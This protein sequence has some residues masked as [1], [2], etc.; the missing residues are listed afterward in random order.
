MRKNI[1]HE[2]RN[3]NTNQS[4]QCPEGRRTSS[5]LLKKSSSSEKRTNADYGG[6]LRCLA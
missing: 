3:Y 6:A 5:K 4:T 2:A 1:V